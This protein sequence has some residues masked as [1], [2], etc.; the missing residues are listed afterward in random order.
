MDMM[1]LFFPEAAEASHLRKISK[2]I[3]AHQRAASRVAQTSTDVRDDLGFLALVLL[4]LV[5]K[6]VEKGVL[7]EQELREQLEKADRLDGLADGKIDPGLLRGAL[8]LVQQPPEAPT[9]TRE[10][11]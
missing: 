1:D 9:P 2:S 7:T 11:R 4:S 3:S 6:L 10:R 5:G 8:G